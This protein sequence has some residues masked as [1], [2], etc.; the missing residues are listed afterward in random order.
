MTMTTTTNPDSD[1]STPTPCPAWC[2]E[3][4]AG[5]LFHQSVCRVFHVTHGE[6]DGPEECG[7]QLQK[8]NDAQADKDEPAAVVVE[9]ERDCFGQ[10]WLTPAE[11][12]KLAGYLVKAA[13]E[14]EQA[15]PDI[16]N[17]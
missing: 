17:A 14:L 4:R 8:W 11:P 16:G 13:G 12:R 3:D 6:S 7:V 5:G 10:S 1:T 2:R 9:V 15:S